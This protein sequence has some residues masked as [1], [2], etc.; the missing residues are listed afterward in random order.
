VA[1]VDIDGEPASG[2]G[3]LEEHAAFASGWHAHRKHQVLYASSGA[4]Q[5]EVGSDQWLL[6]PQRAALIASGVSHRVTARGP[7][8]LRT[9]YL[10]PEV[11][12]G[13]RVPPCSV[14]AVTA[15]AREMLLHAMRW[16]PGH[17]PD[18]TSERFFA[19]LGSL[20]VEWAMD[21]LPVRLPAARSPE[22][23][24]AMAWVLKNLD[25]PLGLAEVARAA[26]VSPR[27]LNRRF[28]REAGMGLRRFVTQARLM[29]ALELLSAPGARVRQTAHAVGFASEAAFTRAFQHLFG[30]R[31]TDYRARAG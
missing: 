16:G 7:I 15:L 27:T 24:R 6:P 13:R 22:L 21:P 25:C 20:S 11:L 10:R 26:A 8:S 29:K 9:V 19:A 3:L 17:A 5:L 2:F 31:P 4:M 30:E 14:F 23:G 28:E 1:T 12:E 18:G